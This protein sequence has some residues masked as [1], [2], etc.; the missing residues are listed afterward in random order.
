M[1]TG[2]HAYARPGK[3]ALVRG[4]EAVS[5]VVGTVLMLGVTLAVFTGLGVVVLSEFEDQQAAPRA[6]LALVQQDSGVLILQQGGEPVPLGVARIVVNVGG[7]EQVTPVSAMPG[8]AALGPTLD[9]GEALCIQGSDGTRCLYPPAQ[10]VRG[11]LLVADGFLMAQSGE[12][13]D[14]SLPLPQPPDLA[15]QALTWTPPAPVTPDAVT[16]SATLANLGGDTSTAVTVTFRLDGVLL[17]TTQVAGP[18]TGGS[19]AVVSSPAW[20]ATPGSHTVTATADPADLIAENDESN[21]ARTAPLDAAAG[22]ADPGFPYEDANGDGLYT[23]GTDGPLAATAVTDGLHQC[24]A[25]MGLTIPASVGAITA[26]AI[27]YSCDGAV[28]LAVG[29]TSTSGAVTVES[30]GTLRLASGSSIASAGSLT[31]APQGE[32]FANGTTL[33]A[34]GA[35]DLGD[36]TA[37]RAGTSFYLNEATIDNTAGTGD[38]SIQSLGTVDLTGAAVRS[39]GDIGVGGYTA[40]NSAQSVLLSGATLDATGGTGQIGLHDL[41]G[42]VLGAGSSTSILARAAIVIEASQDVDLSQATVGNS[43]GSGGITVSGVSLTFSGAT[44]ST[45]GAVVLTG[46][47]TTTCAGCTVSSGGDVTLVGPGGTMDVRGSTLTAAGNRDLKLTVATGFQVLVDGAT[48]ADR[49]NRA[50]VTPNGVA[51][52]TPL[53]GGVE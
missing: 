37:A 9:L 23:V 49:N 22:T 21:N 36:S 46:S 35:V 25:G 53:S 1:S 6:D 7:S 51:S 39:R 11:V 30:G 4:E 15:I 47:G 20:T 5:S 10:D 29:L 31:L 18:V 42:S 14:P 33:T 19:T 13:G 3:A 34:G 40:A 26:A 38:L 41:A 48:F 16:F 8:A 50:D 52:G 45:N 43:A 2:R 28:T 27:D 24:A 44:V 17:G 32:L 12:R